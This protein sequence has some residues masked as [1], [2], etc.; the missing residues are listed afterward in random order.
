VTLLFSGGRQEALP[1]MSKD[2]VAYAVLAAAMETLT[3]R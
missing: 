2:G 1:I 3:T